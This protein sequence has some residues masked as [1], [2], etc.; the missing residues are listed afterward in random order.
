MKPSDKETP[1]ETPV[2]RPHVILPMV[3]FGRRF[4]DEGYA[5]DKPLIEV[6]GRTLMD[7][8]LS[9]L[10]L[11]WRPAVI[12]V[13]REAQYE[14]RTELVRRGFKGDQLVTLAGITQGAACSVLAAAVGLPPDDPVLVMNADQWFK[15]GGP[16]LDPSIPSPQR[17]WTLAMAHSHAIANKWDGFILTFPGKGPAWSYAVTNGT[18]RV[19]HVIE[20]KQVSDFATVG[21]YWWRRAADLVRSI[22]AMI[23]VGQKTNQEFYMSPA[24]NFLPLS[25][26][27]VQIVPVEEFMGLGTPE[28][29]RAFEARLQEG[30]TP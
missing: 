23:A 29:V 9:C 8:S 15:L 21:V 1:M 10:P 4:K 20:K 25:D 6:G 26:K 28:Q 30:W 19:V 14:L 24:Y 5:H 12:A 3:G 11:L 13:V 22:C 18:N 27:N 2:S 17:V 7:W 16:L